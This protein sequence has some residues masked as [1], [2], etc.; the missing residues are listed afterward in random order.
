MKSIKKTKK[1]T[2]SCVPSARMEFFP[3]CSTLYCTKGKQND[4]ETGSSTNPKDLCWSMD[5]QRYPGGVALPRLASRSVALR[6]KSNPV[7]VATRTR[8]QRVRRQPRKGLGQNRA[9]RGQPLWGCR[10]CAPGQANPYGVAALAA[11]IGPAPKG[12][13]VAGA[14]RRQPLWGWGSAAASDASPLW[15]LSFKAADQG[16]PLRGWAISARSKAAPSGLG[17]IRRNPQ[18]GLRRAGRWRGQPLRG[19]GGGDGWG[20]PAP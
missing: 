6:D 13:M 15:G 12:L 2:N 10:S 4:S 9:K 16:Q 19:W 17:S 1:L 18:R 11:E 8:E 7:G 14:R 3:W 20:M 5:G